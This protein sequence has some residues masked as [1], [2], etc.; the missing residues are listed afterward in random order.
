MGDVKLITD[1][2][3]SS[4]CPN[5][6][7]RFERLLEAGDLTLAAYA[8]MWLDRVVADLIWLLPPP[9]GHPKK[10]ELPREILLTVFTG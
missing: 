2:V 7:A 10:S 4:A 1:I 8:A 9:W 5:G 3:R 6:R